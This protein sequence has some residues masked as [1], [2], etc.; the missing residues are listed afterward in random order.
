MPN[1]T[2]LWLCDELKCVFVLVV[3]GHFTLNSK[4]CVHFVFMP[5]QNEQ[6]RFFQKS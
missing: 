5:F 1:S 6:P 4:T 2:I 3:Y